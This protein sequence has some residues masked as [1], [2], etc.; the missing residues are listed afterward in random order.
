NQGYAGTSQTYG[1]YQNGLAVGIDL[2]NNIFNLTR[3]GTGNRTAL[4]F[5]T[6]T[7]TIISDYNDL[8]LTTAANFYTGTYGSTNYNALADWRTGTRSYDQASVAVA[9][10]FAIG[11][12]VPQAPQLNG[13]GQTLARVPRDIDNVLRSTPPDLG[14]YEFSPND[15]AL[16][17]IDAPTAASAAGTSSVVVTVRNAGSVA[18][19]TTTL[20][21]TLNGGPA[22]TQVFTLTPALA[23]AAT[24]QLTFA[25]SVGLPAGTNTLTV[26]ASLPNGQPDGNPANNTLTVTFA[27]AALPANDEPCGAIALTTSPLTSTNV[28]ATTSAQPGIVLPAC[29]PAT[30]PRDV[31]FTFT[32][33][34]TSTTLAFTGAAAGLV[35]VFSSPSCSAGSFTQVFCASS[36][37]SNT[38]FTAPL[39]VAGLVAGTRYYVAVSGYG[40]A[41]AT[42]TFG[43]SA[44]ALL[45]THTSAS[46]TAALQVYP[47]PSATGQLTLRLATLAGPGTAELL[48]ALGQ[49]VRQQPLA[50]PAE[51]QLSTQGLAAGLY[52]LRVQA[53]GEVLTRKVVLQ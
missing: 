27:Q 48:N 5:L 17:S 4:A 34:G 32:P 35:R 46:A 12:W 9:P 53:N 10:A 25:T 43:I 15:V 26:M 24:Q 47:N 36:G 19:A 52:T 28:G 7:S 50:G 41:D 37:A 31:W 6:T 14:A 44:T 18:L 33:S 49:V 21:Y 29:S 22:V 1:F 38:A 42:G 8:Y 30:A 20:S 39:S 23:L 16:V 45:A 40:N 11:S 2:R 3:T 13:A 51:Q